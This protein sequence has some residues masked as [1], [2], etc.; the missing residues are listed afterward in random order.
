M[1]L[2]SPAASQRPLC[3]DYIALPE[4]W[5]PV[6]GGQWRPCAPRLRSVLVLKSESATD[7]E[8]G[9]A[10]IPRVQH[11][12][13]RGAGK[14]CTAAGRLRLG[15]CSKE[16]PLE[17][18]ATCLMLANVEFTGPSSLTTRARERHVVLLTRGGTVSK[19]RSAGKPH[20]H[21]ESR[22]GEGAP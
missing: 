10:S 14:W 9:L 20:I 8:N 15:G 18:P 3:G 22:Q 5:L 11:A 1:A 21:I 6:T 2:A 17:A 7:G 4:R 13:A 12:V 16:G 19:A